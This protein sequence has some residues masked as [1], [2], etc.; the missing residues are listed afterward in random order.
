MTCAK[1][2]CA[3]QA[4]HYRSLSFADRRRQVPKVST[5]DHGTH[6]VDVTEHYDTD[7]QDVTVH[8]APIQLK[9]AALTPGTNGA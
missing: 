2:C 5:D 4:E 7:R 3:D 9:L 8:A 6:T 1:G